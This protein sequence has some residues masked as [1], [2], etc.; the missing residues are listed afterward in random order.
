MH[1]Q[2]PLILPALAIPFT[3]QTSPSALLEATFFPFADRLL[4]SSVACSFSWLWCCLCS[5]L[6]SSTSTANYNL[7]YLTTRCTIYFPVYSLGY[8]VHGYTPG[9]SSSLVLSPRIPSQAA[10]LSLMVTSFLRGT[11]H[12]R[13]TGRQAGSSKNLQTSRKA[14]LV[15]HVWGNTPWSHLVC[16]SHET[17][18]TSVV[19][20]EYHFKWTSTFVYEH[21]DAIESQEPYLA[22]ESLKCGLCLS[23]TLKLVDYELTL[24]D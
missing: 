9:P 5:Q 15:S 18:K 2:H 21:I 10:L 16:V 6:L 19:T 17:S 22:W 14:F 3:G 20:L 11:T 13:A 23:E 24:T 12:P 4:L 8:H 7:R 1:P